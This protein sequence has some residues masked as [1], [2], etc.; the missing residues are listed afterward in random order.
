MLFD[1]CRI[2]GIETTSRLVRSATFEGLADDCGY[3]TSEMLLAYEHLAAGGVGIIITGMIAAGTIEP[4]Q[5]RQIRCDGDDC[6]APLAQL[7]DRVHKHGGKIIAQIVEIGGAIMLPEGPG[8]IIS[9]S[10]IPEKVGKEMQASRALTHDEIQILIQDMGK[11]AARAEKAGFDGIQ[12]HGAHGY[13]I[14]KFLTPFFNQRRDEYGGSLENRARFLLEILTTVRQSTGADFPLWLK[15]NCAD[16][17]QEGGLTF[18][19]CQQ[20]MPL[21]AAGPVNAIEVSGGNMASLPR[22]GPIRAIRRTKEPMYFKPYAEHLAVALKDTPIDVGVVGG[23]RDLHQIED[24]LATTPLAFV[25]M[26]R[27]FLRQPDL[28]NLW[29]NGSDEPAACISCS[30][31]YGTDAIACI[32]HKTEKE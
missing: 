16:F 24:T 28:P 27:P 7:T 4:R 20:L 30:R 3:P 19:D 31:C 12:I 25:S 1:K 18:E 29:R 14:S 13:L 32:F 8:T 23:F 15:L 17:M 6:I 10:G 22:K 9:P 21:L 11:A 5:H 26:S 2:G